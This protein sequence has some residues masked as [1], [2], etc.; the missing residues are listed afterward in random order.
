[1]LRTAQPRAG[2]RGSLAR[3]ACTA[4]ASATA[5][6]AISLSLPSPLL[7]SITISA[8]A[9]PTPEPMEERPLPRG[10]AGPARPPSRQ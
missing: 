2:G 6:S 5:V 10:A 8:P 4:T 9:S 1:M 7:F 3:L